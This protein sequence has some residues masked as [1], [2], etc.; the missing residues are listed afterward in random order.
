MRK[1]KLIFVVMLLVTVLFVCYAFA[2]S[3]PKWFPFNTKN[4]LREWKEKIFKNRV[5][6]VVQPRQEGGY[7]QA[8]SKGACSG[9]VYHIKFYPSKL[10]MISWRWKVK[11]FPKKSASGKTKDGWIERDDY[12]ARVY[13]VFTSWNFLNMQSIEYIWAENLP[14]GKVITSPYF[15]NLKLIVVE[16]GR[17]NLDQW[18]FEERN[19][20]EDYKKAFGRKCRRRVGAIALMT[21]SDNT[22][23]TA[24]A[25]YKDIKVGYKDE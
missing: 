16:S 22:L 24:E 13:V 8:K 1:S 23:S 25:L 17:Q 2:Y 20:Y 15:K 14:E 7:L 3:L 6:Y 19:I 10:P 9:L 18:V 21:D 4:A 11:Q 5:L 12:A